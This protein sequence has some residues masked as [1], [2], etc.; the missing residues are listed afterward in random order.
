MS[1]SFSQ[2]SVLI[3]DQTVKLYSW[4]EALKADKQLVTAIQYVWYE[5]GSPTTLPAELVDFPNLVYLDLSHSPKVT[6]FTLLTKLT[7][8]RTLL[9]GSYTA[10]PPAELWQLSWLNKLKLEGGSSDYKCTT[11]E[12]IEALAA[13]EELDLSFNDLSEIPA[14]FRNLKNLRV[15]DLSYNSKIIDATELGFLPA[16][17]K[18]NISDC[19]VT[20][21]PASFA[22]LN[23]L[24]AFRANGRLD[25]EGISN[26][27]NC[28]L[29]EELALPSYFMTAFPVELLLLPLKSLSLTSC[30]FTDYSFL[31]NFGKLEILS[32]TYCKMNAVPKEI[33]GLTNL[34]YLYLYNSSGLSD[35]SAVQNLTKL[36]SLNLRSCNV[37]SIP[38]SIGTCT[39]LKEVELGN[40][41]G[42]TSI[43]NLGQCKNLEFVDIDGCV[44]VPKTEIAALKKLTG[45]Y[46]STSYDMS[47]KYHFG[48]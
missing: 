6:D 18:L 43:E 32:L 28:T 3:G 23:S 22:N 5:N 39:S 19:S 24:R 13:L 48:N 2:E 40:N 1:S 33:S 47:Y 29:L 37:T 10:I 8:L 31:A 46:V 34:K 16:L 45:C 7:S 4:K 30:Q 11:I 20:E 42:L 27:K 36:E 44:L 9:F 15:I 25:I 38:A 17:E 26:L 35:I 12:G 14:G 21:I 41:V